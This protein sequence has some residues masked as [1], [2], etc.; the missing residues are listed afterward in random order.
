R[1]P[2]DADLMMAGFAEGA[3][4]AAER[5]AALRDPEWEYGWRSFFPEGEEYEW[6]ACA[7][8]EDAEAQIAAAQAKEDSGVYGDLHPL[9]YS[10]WR[11]EVRE[12][13]PWLPVPA[14]ETEGED[15]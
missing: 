7:N 12:P 4:W 15:R 14:D 5:A 3:R 2:Y 10:L 1:S 6:R 9:T 11:R 13:G 8:R